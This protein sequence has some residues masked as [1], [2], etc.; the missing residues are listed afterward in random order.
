MAFTLDANGC[1]RCKS[2]HIRKSQ[3]RNLFEV[4]FGFAVVACR[5]LDCERRFFRPRWY[6]KPPEREKKGRSATSGGA[7]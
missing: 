4:I 6:G 2:V 1:P 7:K 5:C 3:N